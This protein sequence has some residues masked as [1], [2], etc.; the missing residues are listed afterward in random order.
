M[1]EPALNRL[2]DKIDDKSDNGERSRIEK[3][4]YIRRGVT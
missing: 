4:N 1:R 3:K 2:G